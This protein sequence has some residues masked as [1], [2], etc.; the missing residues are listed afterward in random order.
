MLAEAQQ[1]H[2]VQLSNYEILTAPVDHLGDETVDKLSTSMVR[3][4]HV[5]LP[6]EDLTSSI[7][8]KSNLSRNHPETVLNQCGFQI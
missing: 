7:I 8:V 4:S 1:L 6:T 2:S 5:L 3:K